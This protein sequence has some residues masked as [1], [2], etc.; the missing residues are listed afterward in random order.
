[1]MNR[2]FI[3]VLCGLSLVAGCL[4]FLGRTSAQTSVAPSRITQAI[5]E[6][7]LTILRGNTHPFARPEFDRGVAPP[8][9]PEEHMLLVLRRSPEQ[10]AAV[11]K[12]LAAQHEKSSPYY[13]KALTPEEIGRQFGAS[14]ADIQT[15][16]SWLQSHGFAVN[17]VA[18]TRSFIDFSG[19]AAQVSAAFHT[20]IHK[21][22]VNG[23]QHWANASDPAIPSALVPAVVG[24]AS[25]HNFPRKAGSRFHGNFRR[26]KST[27]EVRPLKKDFTMGTGCGV[28]NGACY[29]LGPGDFAAIYGLNSLY[30]SGCCGLPHVDGT[31]QA[32]AIVSQSDINPADFNNFRSQ[33]GLPAGTL[34]IIHNPATPDP[35]IQEASGDE[36][37]SDLDTQWSGAVARGA[38]IDL[39][40][41]SSTNAGAG[42]DLSAAYIVDNASNPAIF[43]IKPAVVSESYGNCELELGNSANSM[44]NTLW[45][46]ADL[47][48]VVPVVSAG[49]QGSAGCANVDPNSTS[50]QPDTTGLAISGVS[51][52]IY[53]IAVG[54]T[55]FNQLTDQTTFWN[56]TGTTDGTGATQVTAKGYIPET[57]WNDSCTNT[58][59]GQVGFSA[60]PETNCNDTTVSPSFI[61]PVGGGGGLSNC[62][63]SNGVTASSCSGGY[64]KPTWQ[65]GVTPADGKRDVPDVSLFAGDGLVGSFYVVC[66]QDQD[67]GNVACSLGNVDDFQGFGGTS[68][69]AQ[70]FAGIMTLVAQA[71]GGQ[72]TPNQ[73]LYEIAAS[74]P[75]C[76]SAANPANNC[77]IY[78][79]TVGNNEAP[80]VLNEALNCSS[81]APAAVPAAFFKSSKFTAWILPC[82][83][84]LCVSSLPFALHARRRNWTRAFAVCAITFALVVLACCGGGGGGGGGQQ[85]NGILTGYSAGSGFDLATGLGSVNATNL[86]S[87]PRW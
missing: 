28:Q 29:L 38:E 68:V 26:D 83:L 19:T 7:R 86:V 6:T 55:D 63:S 60:N 59:W 66:E 74:G 43:P 75:V 40:V 56:A 17:E 48:L 30:L 23:A 85:T 84:A 67:P 39:V 36:G 51:S 4:I 14:D 8:D 73:T 18:N 27:G 77:V 58:L 70:T 57:T 25:L 79:T 81:T 10:E 80:C 64:A 45:A 24:V 78:D 9:L 47:E 54:G 65:M 61:I 72:S 50:P 46:N 16:T 35:G 34:N 3:G 52:T 71:H 15:I 11:Q 53:N 13:K 5:D 41:S 33:F 21:Y 49:D 22:I 44:Y 32:I 31:G 87:S 82:L 37:E 2:K 76:T 42:V 62:T 12:L 1:M 69:S 20:D